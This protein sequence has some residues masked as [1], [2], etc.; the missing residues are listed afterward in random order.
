MS[1]VIILLENQV[2]DLHKAL[3]TIEI[4]LNRLRGKYVTLTRR[5]EK[6]ERESIATL[7]SFMEES[8]K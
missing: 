6:L 4:K 3:N 8:D 1:A 7:R 2:N 5:V